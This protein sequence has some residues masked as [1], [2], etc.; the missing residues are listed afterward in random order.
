MQNKTKNQLGLFI[1]RRD[2]RL[3]DNNALN[4]AADMCTTIVP[5]FIFTPEQVGT[6]NT[7]RSKRAIQFMIEGLQD[8]SSAISK[9]GGHLYTLYGDPG[10]VVKQCIHLFDADAVFF[11]RDYTPYSVERDTHVQN[12]CESLKVPCLTFGDSYLHEPGTLFSKSRQPYQKFTP[13]YH[14]SMRHPIP[15]PS[16]P[17]AMPF[18]KARNQIPHTLSLSLEE[19]FQR[20]VKTPEKKVVQGGRTQAIQDL[21]KAVKTQHSYTKNHN[22]LFLPTSRLSAAIKFGCVSIREVYTK[23]RLNHD[24]VRQLVWRDFYAQILYTF[25]HVLG[26]AMKPSYNKMRWRKST[27]YLEAW[28]RGETGF[29]VVD[30]AMREVNETGYMHNRGRLIVASFLVKT[31][32]LDW[33]E[34]EKY[35][36]TRLTDYDPASNNGN[37]QWIA[38]SG[39]DSQPYFRIFN[40][41]QQSVNFDH[42][43]DYIKHWLPVLQDVPSKSIHRWYQDYTK[44]PDVHYPKPIVD[45]TKQK[46]LVLD[47]YHSLFH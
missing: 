11:N 47:M 30:A 24:F 1:F 10:S 40:P 27:R 39:A 33:R 5:V 17:R 43:A 46:D 21:E 13:Y 36:A 38:G 14:E 44:Y 9:Q 19:A 20:F 6:K 41:W 26:K 15:P 37:W 42:E 45:Y 23:M 8:L 2:Y 28:Q 22:S 7:F 32:L 29:P 34:G 3:I 18:L 25:P 35:F 16:R 12:I 4:A 31:L